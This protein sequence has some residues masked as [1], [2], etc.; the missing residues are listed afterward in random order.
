MKDDVKKMYEKMKIVNDK[1]R[2][3]MKWIVED[4]RKNKKSVFGLEELGKKVTHTIKKMEGRCVK[5]EFKTQINMK[6]EKI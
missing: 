5:Y 1:M 2:K 6:V 3:K 4:E